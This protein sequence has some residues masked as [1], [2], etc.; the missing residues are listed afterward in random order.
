MRIIS[1]MKRGCPIAAPR[2]KNTRPTYD[3]VREALFGIIQ[4]EI[5]DKDVLDL[6]AGSG[7]LGLEALSRYA[8]SALFN[9]SSRESIAAIRSNIEKLGFADRAE[10]LS[11]DYARAIEQAA[12]RGR[13][14]D[15]VFLDPPY[16]SGL[17]EPAMEKL[18]ECRALNE[19]FLIVA[20]H[21]E[22]FPPKAGEAFALRSAKRYGE[23][24]LSFFV[25]G[26]RA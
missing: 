7:A 15:I 13:R 19:G 1:G 16:A 10:V 24:A 17:I 14:F 6:F 9:D 4:F 20:E 8:K 21:H 25:E 2:G 18:I 12:Y 11:M 26:E 22:K 3:K 5:A 23:T